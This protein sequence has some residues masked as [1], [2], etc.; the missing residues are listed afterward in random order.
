[1]CGCDEA[2][3]VRV[4]ENDDPDSKFWGWWSNE[5]NE[6]RHVYPGKVLVEICFPYGT[7]IM[8]K[9]GEGKLTGVDVEI[10]TDDTEIT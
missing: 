10:L 1:M 3:H 7:D 2:F 6:F 9:H 4:T 5:R 8:E